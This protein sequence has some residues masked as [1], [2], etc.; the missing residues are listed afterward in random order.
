MEKQIVIFFEG[1]FVKQDASILLENEINVDFNGQM[2]VRFLNS[3]GALTAI[4]GVDGYGNNILSEIAFKDAE[5]Y[6]PGDAK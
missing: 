4:N 5:I 2:M 6:F 3:C 1:H